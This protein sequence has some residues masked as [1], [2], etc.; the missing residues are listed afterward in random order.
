M[1][2]RRVLKIGSKTNHTYHQYC[3]CVILPGLVNLALGL[4]SALFL[5][6]KFYCEHSAFFFF[7]SSSFFSI[8]KP[9]K[10][11]ADLELK[12]SVGW[13]AL[14]HCTSTGHQ[15]MV[16][17]LLD[18]N[19]DAN[20]KWVSLFALKRPSKKKITICSHFWDFHDSSLIH[21]EPGSGFTPLMEAAASGHEI[22]VQYLLD[23]VSRLLCWNILVCECKWL[24][25]R[26]CHS[27]FFFFATST[28][29]VPLQHLKRWSH[30]T[31]KCNWH[32]S[33]THNLVILWIFRK[34]K[35]MNATPKVRQRVLWLW[36][37]A[38]PKLSASL[39]HVLQEWNQV[40]V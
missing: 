16:K 35:W 14:F 30:I 33:H 6:F 7:F 11:G 18:N 38:I 2:W 24:W 28:S 9:K 8:L 1:F 13:T 39:T 26:P 4:D 37:T 31:G 21:R 22:I 34:L 15:Q 10:Q 19:A 3:S 36:C 20:V 32:D 12:D 40:L 29:P 5:S 17:F 27:P 23:H 25:A